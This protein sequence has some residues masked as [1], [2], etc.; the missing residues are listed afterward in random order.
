MALNLQDA[1]GIMAVYESIVRGEK[2]WLTLVYASDMNHSDELTLHAHG[3]EGLSQLKDIM[4]DTVSEPFIAFYREE[5]GCALLNYIPETLSGVRR[6]RVLVHSRRLG[7]LF[8]EHIT[9]ITIDDLSNISPTTLY[10]ALTETESPTQSEFPQPDT[11]GRTASQPA[12][13]SN[14][15][16]P[17]NALEPVRRS[18]SE[19]HNPEVLP[20]LPGKSESMFTKVLR[21]KKKTQ[22]SGDGYPNHPPPTPPKEEIFMVKQP[23]H[24][25]V[26]A[27]ALDHY[28]M[29]LDASAHYSSHRRRSRS[30]SEFAVISHSNTPEGGPGNQL[31]SD[32]SK[33]VP[34]LSLPL[35][36]K[37]VQTPH[38]VD[39]AER[40]RRRLIAQQQKRA[41]QEAARKAE[42]QRLADIKR[43]K[44]DMLRQEAEEEEQRRVAIEKELRMAV[45][46]RKRKEQREMEEEESKR[47]EIEERKQRDRERR[48]EETRRLAEWREEQALLARETLSRAQ[49]AKRRED[50][51]RMQRIKTVKSKVKD[52]QAD[53]LM[54]G[55]V[56]MQTSD[57]LVWKRR[58]FR[59]DGPSV[60]FH[61]SP[62]DVSMLEEVKLR[63][64]VRGLREWNEG[65]DDLQSVPHSFV[66]EFLDGRE[67]WSMFT[68]SEE[69][70]YKLLGLFHHTAGL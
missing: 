57:N 67:P 40:A 1:P 28:G 19:P 8:T 31:P 70:K 63:G 69:E 39:A 21:R 29:P 10:N 62:L 52:T 54:T 32:R 34:Q 37:W 60:F 47:R 12:N 41:E 17:I 25:Q 61:R 14:K 53:T 26:S 59:M 46:M 9:T 35:S 30:L 33:Y 50:A 23:H 7:T 3:S 5:L 16:L 49:E 68:D 44:E 24:Y 2:D 36:G 55:W 18:A 65:Y 51:E 48:L 56:T 66:V 13:Y 27:Q 45:I 11:M 20:P 38:L 6:A 15:P 64:K 58:F 42:A 43:Q 22:D 4:Q